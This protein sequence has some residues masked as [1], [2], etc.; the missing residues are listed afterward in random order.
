MKKIWILLLCLTSGSPAA[1][2]ASYIKSAVYPVPPDQSLMQSVESALLILQKEAIQEAGVLV[3]QVLTITSQADGQLSD[4]VVQQLAAAVTLTRIISQAYD[5]KELLLT[6]EIQID[7]SQVMTALSQW[8][9]LTLV[10]AQ[11]DTALQ[12]LATQQA[13]REDAELT[14]RLQQRQTEQQRQQIVALKAQV[15][16][17]E[18]LNQQQ[19]AEQQRLDRAQR[20]SDKLKQSVAMRIDK[21]AKRFMADLT[22]YQRAWT[23]GMTLQDARQ[24]HRFVNKPFYSEADKTNLTFFDERYTERFAQ[25]RHDTYIIQQAHINNQMTYLLAV[26]HKGQQR[27]KNLYVAKELDR[28]PDN[29][30]KVSSTPMVQS[31]L[32]NTLRS[33]TA[34][35]QA[36]SGAGF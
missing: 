2:A 21:Q 22:F 36:D 15:Q 35:V 30:I 18:R 25:P 5:G 29:Q 1:S 7:D 14:L 16:L 10:Q 33:N 4:E 17:L 9:E 11:R 6:A 27:I 26:T 23:Q 34:D 28:T 8:H 19:L 31:A 13:A 32:L 24:F 12:A 3:K 20:Q